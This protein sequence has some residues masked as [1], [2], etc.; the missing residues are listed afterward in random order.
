MAQPSTSEDSP[1][2]GPLVK[3]SIVVMPTWRRAAAATSA[4]GSMSADSWTVRC[5][6]ASMP[7][8]CASGRC[9]SSASK[10]ALC[11]Q[12]RPAPAPR[13]WSR[14]SPNAGAAPASSAG[15]VPAVIADLAR[16]LDDPQKHRRPLC[17]RLLPS[18]RSG[19]AGALPL[20]L[21]VN[22]SFRAAARRWRTSSG[23]G[24]RAR[25]RR[26][27][28]CR[29]LADRYCA[30]RRHAKGDEGRQHLIRAGWNAGPGLMQRSGEAGAT[31]GAGSRAVG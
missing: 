15:G 5:S 8:G 29:C 1:L 9:R 6:P 10:S 30:T 24:V 31:S 7:E 23:H 17:T 22:L 18:G 12:S 19:S 14:K 4:A 16:E 28:R 20:V 27:R 2:A 13:S 3:R 11:R 26:S 25:C 21:A